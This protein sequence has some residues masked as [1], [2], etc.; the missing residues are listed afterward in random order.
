MIGG[1][2]QNINLRKYAVI[3]GGWSN[4]ASGYL[5][6]VGGGGNDGAGDL[7]NMASGE[8]S[9][10]VGG[11][12]NAASG[13]LSA[14][15]GGGGNTASAQGATVPGGLNNS[16][17]GDFSGISGGLGNAA[18]GTGA[19]VGGGGVDILDGYPG[20]TASGD[21]STVS[22]GTGNRAGNFA[23]VSGGATNVASG[24]GAAVPG[25][26][27]NTALGSTSLAAGWQAQAL[28]NG[29]FVWADSQGSAFASTTNDQFSI[30]AANGLRVS[31][32]GGTTRMTLGPNGQLTVFG[33]S[34]SGV[35]GHST[36]SGTSGVYGQSD[37][38]GYGLA[39]RSTGSGTAVYGDNTSP[40]GWAGYFN[41]NVRVTGTINP[42]SDRNMKE[43][44]QSLDTR[45]V[46]TKVAAMPIQTWVYKG[47]T[48]RRHLGPVAQDF[49]A[50]FGLNGVDDKSIATVDADGVALAAIQGLNQKVEAQQAELRQKETEITELKDQLSGLRELVGAL[51]Q[52]LNR[53]V[54]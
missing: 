9:S 10:V 6:F 16:A 39:G 30:R 54:P 17:S 44:F 27:A 11:S 20:N 25:G 8:A 51:N 45:E 3:C 48:T 24:P 15:G 40:L 32:S 12:Q 50:A 35:E 31:G 46:L 7:G 1:G 28:H 2:Q 49:H 26:L 43:D 37:G 33:T 29:A 4:N 52:K 18:N 19:F 41:G 47:D 36:G 53:G 14:V 38:Q 5:A 23:T 34:G 42:S 22:G 21:F 13:W